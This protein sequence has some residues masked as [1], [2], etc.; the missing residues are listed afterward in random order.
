VIDEALDCMQRAFDLD[1]D[2]AR[3]VAHAARELKTPSE[4]IDKWPEANAL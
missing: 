2:R 1:R 3:T 4:P